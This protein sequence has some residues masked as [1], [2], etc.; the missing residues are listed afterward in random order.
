MS[1]K[2]QLYRVNPTTR[3]PAALQEVDLAHLGLQERSDLQEWVA[4]NPGIVGEDLLIIAKEFD[5]FDRT[6][7]RLDLLA[8]DTSGGLVVIELKR[9]DSGSDAYWQAIKYASYL[10]R[11]SADKIISML[12]NHK[13]VTEEDAGNMLL[14]HLNSDDLDSLNKYQRIILASHRFAPEVTSA[15]LWLNEKASDKNLITCVQLTPYRGDES[16]SLF[17]QAN[18]IIPVPVEEDYEVQIGSRQSQAGASGFAQNLQKTYDRNQRDDVTRFLRRSADIALGSLTKGK[19]PDKRSRWAGGWAGGAY[20]HRYYRVWYSHAPWSNW[21]MS[22]RMNLYRRDSE[23]DS[24]MVNVEFGYF[25]GE[26][27]SRIGSMKIHE[28][29]VVE[30][31]R[32][33]VTHTSKDLDDAFSQQLG[34]TLSRLIEA[35][36]P[37]VDELEGD[38]NQ[39]EALPAEAL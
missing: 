24:W 13:Q 27:G 30:D 4:T 2:P 6:S 12:A 1:G 28:S 9:D 31:D 3:E 16:D 34:E 38:P 17:V 5:R 8:V 21:G 23:G 19:R 22:Y 39:E 33:F 26:L 37:V 18:T 15:A 35:I 36:T 25:S 32:V 7:E 20:D 29:Q 11:A 14:N 10:R